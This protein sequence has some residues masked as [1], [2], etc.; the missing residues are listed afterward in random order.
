MVDEPRLALMQAGMLWYGRQYAECAVMLSACADETLPYA[1]A[2]VD[3]LMR[4][5]EPRE[6]RWLFSMTGVCDLGLDEMRRLGEGAEVTAH[7]WSWR[8]LRR[9]LRRSPWRRLGSRCQ[10]ADG[11][12]TSG[13]RGGPHTPRSTPRRRAGGQHRTTFAPSAQATC[14]R[15]QPTMPRAPGAKPNEPP[16][17]GGRPWSKK[18]GTPCAA[19]HRRTRRLWILRSAVF[20]RGNPDDWST[21]RVGVFRIAA[22]TVPAAFVGRRHA[23]A[24]SSGS[25]AL[26]IAA[27]AL[28]HSRGLQTVSYP[29]LTVPMVPWAL[30]RAGT[31]PAAIDVAERFLPEPNALYD[32]A[33]HARGLTMV[34]TAGLMTPE[35]C[36]VIQQLRADG[37]VVLEDGS[38]AHGCALNGARAGSLGDLAAFSLYATKVITSGE[39]GMVVLDDEEMAEWIRRLRERGKGALESMCRNA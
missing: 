39:G 8:R 4:Y 6:A 26:E 38:H 22:L 17:A 12:V 31:M 2:C 14:H 35:V 3:R 10:R 36:S 30:S 5:P 20:G 15:L 18:G 19:T 23:V 24:V 7:P 33:R 32:H 27:R 9:Q 21:F 25:A 13:S 11:C 37:V 34:W 29:V 28:K 16:G 1:R